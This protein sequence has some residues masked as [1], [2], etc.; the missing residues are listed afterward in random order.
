MGKG[1]CGERKRSGGRCSGVPMANGK[2]QWHGGKRSIDLVAA[3]FRKDASIKERA[4]AH[5]L[6]VERGEGIVTIRREEAAS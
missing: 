5:G 6:V 2:C 4:A 3:R 1:V